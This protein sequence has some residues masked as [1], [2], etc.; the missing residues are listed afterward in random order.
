V[1]TTDNIF[2]DKSISEIHKGFIDRNINP[3]D[4]A[5]ACITR[6]EALEDRYLA[7]VCFDKESLLNQANVSKDHIDTGKHIRSL[8]GIPVGVKDI[9]NTMKFPTQMGSPIWKG[10]TPGN[11][12]RVVYQ[13]KNAGGVIP[14]KTVTA[15][16]AVHTLDKTLN[17]HDVSR[18]P[19]TSSSGSAVAIA[20]GMVPVALGTQTAGSIVRPASFCGVYGCKPSFGLIPRTGMLKTTDSLDTIGFFVAR[21]DD[22]V[23]VF[24]SIRVYGP[25]YPF[26]HEALKDITRQN[27]SEDRPW[28]IA[29]ARTHTWQY[30]FDYAKSALLQWAKKLSEHKSI[31]IIETD[32]PEATINAHSIHS[33]IYDKTLSYYFKEEYNKSVLVSPI[34]KEIIRR[35]NEISVQQYHDALKE[36]ERLCHIMDKYLEGFDAMISLST[37]GEAPL[38][39]ITEYQDPALIWTM[40]HLPVVCAPA[41]ISPAALPFGVQLVARK[42]NDYLL[43]KLIAHLRSLELLP[44]STNPMFKFVD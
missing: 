17:P 5:H 8:E 4:V 21:C 23:R 30:A 32:L 29:L 36:Q 39:S 16:F 15:E 13:T 22:L 43:F 3:I 38:R 14:G 42:Y 20:L 2:L 41:F 31:E 28:R 10:F 27:K 44:P 26:S 12:A 37:A 6:Y 19:G 40:T 7:W 35:G 33:V 34:M 1:K 9:F 24:D 11:D 18:T 25:N